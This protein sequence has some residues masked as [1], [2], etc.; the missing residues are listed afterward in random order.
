MNPEVLGQLC[1]RTGLMHT[2]LIFGNVWM[3]ITEVILM[4]ICR[5][6]I[7]FDLDSRTMFK[8]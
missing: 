8:Y 3:A 7:E 4:Q 6:W 2:G 1:M 5:Y